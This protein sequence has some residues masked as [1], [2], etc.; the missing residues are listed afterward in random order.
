M[1]GLFKRERPSLNIGSVYIFYGWDQIEEKR[2]KEI[3]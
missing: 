3:F 1:R 2:K